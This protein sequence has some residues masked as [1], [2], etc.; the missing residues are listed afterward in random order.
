MS[1]ARKIP[2]FCIILATLALSTAHAAEPYGT[3]FDLAVGTSVEVGDEGLVVGF[4]SILVDSRCPEDAVC[5]WEGDAEAALWVDVPG[6]PRQEFVLHTS[7][8]FVQSQDVGCAVIHLLSVVPLASVDGP[9]IDPAD[10]VV[11]LLVVCSGPIET[12]PHTW[13]ATK[14]SYR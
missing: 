3:P 4:T 9:P 14:V 13:G 1:P 5:F 12:E 2:V 8:M 6:H 10:Y 11:Q 7:P